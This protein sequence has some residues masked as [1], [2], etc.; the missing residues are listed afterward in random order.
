MRAGVRTIFLDGILG[1]NLPRGKGKGSE[2]AVVFFFGGGVVW[3]TPTSA[4]FISGF[5]DIPRGSGF[6]REGGGLSRS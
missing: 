4:G 2:G 1:V 6:L 5:G 3:H